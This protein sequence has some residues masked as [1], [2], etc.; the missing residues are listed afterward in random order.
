VTVTLDAGAIGA[1]FAFVGGDTC[2]GQPLAAKAKCVV[3]VAFAP[4]PGAPKG[5]VIGGTL[6]Y[7]FTYGGP[8]VIDGNVSVTL[9]GTVK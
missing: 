7:D 3:M 2:G 4:Q 8:P 9:K 6:S 5:P 1:D